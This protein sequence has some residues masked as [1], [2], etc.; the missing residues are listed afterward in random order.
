MN[1]TTMQTTMQKAGHSTG[2]ED[3]QATLE[4]VF[5]GLTRPRR[6]PASEAE[7]QLLALA[8]PHKIPHEDISL[9]A[10]RWG[11]Q[12]ASGKRV[13]LV[14]GWESRAGHWAAFVPALTQAGFQVC[15][16]DAPAHG[17]SPGEQSDVIAGGRAVLNAAAYF[18]PLHAVIAHSAGSASA[19]YAYSRG[20]QVHASVQLSGP[21]SLVRVLANLARATRLP[22]ELAQELRARFEDYLGQSAAV[23]DLERLQNGLRHPALLLHD[24]DDAEVPYAESIALHAA[25]SLATLEAAQG[26]GHRRLLKDPAVVARVIQF[27]Q[28]QDRE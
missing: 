3:R 28:E 18:G 2:V 22:P 10:W 15:A 26:L 21:S 17:E 23:M 8:E 27:L 16:Y 4:A 9:S 6:K 24:P 11:S 5:Q 20:L 19:L 12:N 7:Q 25:W 1:D 14:H 13:L